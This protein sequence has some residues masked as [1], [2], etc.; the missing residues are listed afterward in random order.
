MFS[1]VPLDLH[2]PC[3][4]IQVDWACRALPKSIPNSPCYEAH[5]GNRRQV[6]L[7]T[8]AKK[9]VTPFK[10]QCILIIRVEVR[11]VYNFKLMFTGT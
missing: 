9:T 10:V 1:N 5:H 3:L 11:M 7:D 6:L 8:Q 2:A 4:L